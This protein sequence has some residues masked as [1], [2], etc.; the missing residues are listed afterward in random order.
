MGQN[1]TWTSRKIYETL[2]D[3]VKFI[4]RLCEIPFPGKGS[5]KIKLDPYGVRFLRDKSMMRFV[6][7]SRRV[8]FSTLFSLEAFHQ[9]I[10]SDEMMS[11]FVSKKEDQSCE[12][13]RVARFA[14]RHL[15]KP[16]E[17]KVT[18]DRET[19]L[20][21]GNGSRIVALSSSPDAARGLTGNAYLDEWHF[22]PNATEVWKAASKTIAIGADSGAL[23]LTMSSTARGKAGH[24]YDT[25]KSIQEAI[26]LKQEPKWSFHIV[27]WSDCPRLNYEIIRD[28]CDT[29]EEFLMEFCCTFV[30]ESMTLFPFV[31]LDKVAKDLQQY[32]VYAPPPVYPNRARFIGVDFGRKDSETAIIL[33]ERSPKK[34]KRTVTLTEDDNEITKEIEEYIWFVRYLETLQD[35]P[36]PEQE[37]F[38]YEV[39]KAFLPTRVYCDQTSFGL[40]FVDHLKQGHLIGSSVLEGVTFTNET[41]ERLIYNL[42]GMMEAGILFIPDNR[43]LINQLH[44]IHAEPTPSGRRKFTGK[45]SGGN[46]D[47]VWALALA[48]QDRVPRKFVGASGAPFKDVEEETEKERDL[49]T[50]IERMRNDPLAH[51]NPEKAHPFYVR[52]L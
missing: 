11:F 51:I 19:K 1:L 22:V 48:V 23:R 45:I 30:D 14:S 24:Y 5:I 50:L 46:D 8:G 13:L 6:L 33:T 37:E 7:K 47:L 42:K 36:A 28:L 25:Y 31:L 18:K 16:F 2:I 10:I 38:I 15:P 26:R 49:D 34:V 40:P 20:E 41:K 3:P 35:V 44:A 17:I 9:S 43:R 52:R 12:M 27:K 4:E 21:F 39:Y 32:S 29:E